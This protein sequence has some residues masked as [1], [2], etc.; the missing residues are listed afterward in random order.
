MTT[1]LISF[2][3][4]ALALALVA[5]P[6]S[7][8]GAGGLDQGVQPA[9]SEAASDA[10]RRPFH[11]S[12]LIWD[13]SVTTQT[14][15]IGA[16]YQSRNPTYEMTLRL[17]PRYYLIDD[18]ARSLS[19]RAD[20]RL[21]REFTN[22]DTTTERG[23]WDFADSELSLLDAETIAATSQNRTQLVLRAPILTF[24][25]S[26]ASALGGRILGL[27][28]GVGL[29]QYLTLR[30][31]TASVLRAVLVRPRVNYSYEFVDAK[32][33]TNDRI[34]RIRLDSDGRSAPSDQL[35]G[36]AFTQHQLNLSARADLELARSL[37]FV[38]EFGM[39]YGYR[40]RQRE[41]V[42]MCLSTGCA[43]VPGR[44]DA[45]RWGVS[46]LF[47]VSL[48]YEINHTFE[49]SAGYLNL[50]PQLG[51][52]GRRRSVFYSP[53]ARAFLALGI[54]LDSLYRQLRGQTTDEPLRSANRALSARF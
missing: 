17:A 52:D 3:S 9:A 5:A 37:T 51:A 28:A 35:S 1:S 8:H 33:A 38:S 23:E 32:V 18:A 2:A 48:D 34:D 14:L 13:H 46:T 36:A 30:G 10:E 42:E 16:D 19:V 44:A 50:S 22:S 21:V 20:V 11:D 41:A 43:E 26:K 31:E 24:P 54:S 12:V 27:G 49:L 53:E 47:A 4:L 29:D 25:T 15:G 7:A 40:Y 6:S 45:T 39:R